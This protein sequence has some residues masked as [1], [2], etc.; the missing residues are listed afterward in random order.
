MPQVALHIAADHPAFPGHFPGRPLAPGV[1]LLQH[2]QRAIEAELSATV[3]GLAAVKFLSPVL[4]G[5]PLDVEFNAGPAGV[6]FEIRSDT[7]QV[8]TGTFVLA[9]DGSP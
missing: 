4:P 1:L 9:Q 5:Q 2:A 7:R 8:A 6:R 3:R